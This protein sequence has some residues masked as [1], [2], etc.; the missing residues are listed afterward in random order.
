MS[1]ASV[2]EI[3]LI[4]PAN[5]STGNSTLGPRQCVPFYLSL[6]KQCQLFHNK[7]VYDYRAKSKDGGCQH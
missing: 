4:E 7:V 5:S 6:L 3:E 1:A 2:S